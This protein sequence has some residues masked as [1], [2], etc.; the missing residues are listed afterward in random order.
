MSNTIDFKTCE[1]VAYLRERLPNA[2]VEYQCTGAMHKF[3]IVRDGL[4]Y[5]VSFPERILGSW[6]E[7]KLKSMLRPVVERNAFGMASGISS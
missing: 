2:V 4:E 1:I 7:D 3:R 5:Q 6:E